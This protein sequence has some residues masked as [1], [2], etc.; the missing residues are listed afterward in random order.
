MAFTSLLENN[1]W[2][3]GKFIVFSEVLHNSCY[4]FDYLL[5]ALS[6]KEVAELLILLEAGRQRAASIGRC[7]D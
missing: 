3:F 2:P 4:L 1:H 5:C 7:I 6:V